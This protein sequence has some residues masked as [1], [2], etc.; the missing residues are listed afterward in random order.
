M[1][2]CFTLSSKQCAVCEWSGQ[3]R[4]GFC[5]RHYRRFM[6]TG[7]PLKDSNTKGM[8]PEQK[9]RFW[10]WDEVLRTTELGVCWE[11]RGDKRRHGYGRVAINGKGI[12]VPR[13]AYECWVGPI[14]DGAL[15]RH[16]CDNPPCMNP[17][18][19]ETG[20]FVQNA[21]DMLDRGR[22]NPPIG[23]K[24]GVAR[25]TEAD[26]VRIRALS[27]EGRNLTELSKMFGVSISLV[28]M[29]KNRKRWAHVA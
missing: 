23:V 2:G 4:R 3:L 11:W 6:K 28:S 24:N 16:K 22:H 17:H 29:I 5:K 18:H 14:P 8:T 20:D 12:V 13:V 27:A 19:L 21:Q 7:D 15:I 25:I 10:G 1:G 9:L 26:V